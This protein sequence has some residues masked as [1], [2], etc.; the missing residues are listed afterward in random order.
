MMIFSKTNP[1]P[2]GGSTVIEGTAPGL[3]NTPLTLQAHGAHA[4][5][6]TVASTTTDGSGHYSF[7]TQTPLVSTFY[8]VTGGGRSSAVLYQGVKYVL[9]ATPSTTTV[10][11]GQPITF[12]GT[13]S[14]ARAGHEIWIEKQNIFGTGF[15]PVAVGTVN[16]DGSYSISRAFFAPGTDVLR[17]KIPGDPENGG[18]ASEP[19]TITVNPLP[20]A[21]VPA[22]SPSNGKLP[23]E[24]QTK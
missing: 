23:A 24:G 8:K 3:A 1:I 14:P 17:V 21:K 11:S 12:T 20:G 6:T 16:A 10:S 4:K 9:T 15:H 13:V 2:L 7:P 5:F 18:T 22:E 19:V